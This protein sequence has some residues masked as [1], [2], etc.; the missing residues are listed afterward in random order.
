[1]IENKIDYFFGRAAAALWWLF[2]FFFYWAGIIVVMQAVGWI[3]FA[4]WQP[5]PLGALFLSESGQ[6]LISFYH[7]DFQA[8][9]IVPA[10]GSNIGIESVAD[11]FAG[12]FIGLK[13]IF[14]FILSMPL[15]IWLCITGFFCFYVSIVFGEK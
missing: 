10:M 5:L 1:M 6:A 2:P 13:K 12:N 14:A 3:K 15:V 9:N 8:L 4:T 11:S 7:D